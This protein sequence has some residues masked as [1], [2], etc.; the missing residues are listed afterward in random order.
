[1]TP[2]VR[3]RIDDFNRSR[4][5]EDVQRKYDAMRADPFVFFRGTAHL[6][7]EDWPAATPLD[8]APLVWATGDLH[9]ENFGSYRGDTGLTY[10]DL[11]DFDESALAPATRDPARFL[12]SA[13]LAAQSLRLDSVTVNEL[14]ATYLDAASALTDGK[15]RWIERATATGMIRDL[16]RLAKLRTRRRLLAAR[17]VVERGRPRIRVDGTRAFALPAQQRKVV[18]SC[19]DTF[20]R[21]QP[22]PECYTVLDVAGRIAGMGSLGT[23]RYVVLIRGKRGSNE[24]RLLDV[25][26]APSSTLAKHLGARLSRAQPRWPNDAARI[27]AI[28][29]RMQAISPALLST[30]SL[31]GG[32]FVVRELQPT[33]DRLMLGRWNGKLDRLREVMVAMGHLTAW[34]QLRSSSRD[35]SATADALIE[36]ARDKRA[37]RDLLAYARHYAGQA[38]RDWRE[39]RATL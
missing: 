7:W 36:F 15:A 28:Q 19:I 22:D 39:F 10:F 12:T 37:R 35:G 33:E 26:E 32:R 14:S 20:A 27:V 34:A 13:R 5:P 18:K 38:K 11:N 17:T 24:E 25:K 9:L 1:M 8:D 23:R 6:F 29:R 2:G 16:L 3:A 21:S 4:R 30:V 31:A